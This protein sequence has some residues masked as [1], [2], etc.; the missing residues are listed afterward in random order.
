MKRDCRASAIIGASSGLSATAHT[1][2][3][4][5]TAARLRSRADRFA[6]S[7]PGGSGARFAP[8]PG[9]LSLDVTA[10]QLAQATATAVKN[11]QWSR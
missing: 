6:P 2:Q 11:R 5:A 1:S 10:R 7:W 8:L 9:C 3:A 4:P